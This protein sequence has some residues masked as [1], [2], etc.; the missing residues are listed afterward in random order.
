MPQGKLPGS[1][2]EIRSYPYATGKICILCPNAIVISAISSGCACL[3]FVASA[4]SSIFDAWLQ[5]HR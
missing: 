1:K 5:D 2:D 4:N 3:I